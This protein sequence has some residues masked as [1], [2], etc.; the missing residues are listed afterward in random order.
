MKLAAFTAAALVA[1]SSASAMEIGNTGISLGA[2][3]VAEYTVDAGNMTVVLTP[4]LAYTAWGVSLAASTDL[5]VYNNEFV[6]MNALDTLP[7]IDLSA[8]YSIMDNASAYV[9][10]SWDLETMDRGEVTLG[11]SFSF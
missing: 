1:A 11:V 3:A 6:L 5:S 4:E 8:T 9:K 2:E 10:S 7:V